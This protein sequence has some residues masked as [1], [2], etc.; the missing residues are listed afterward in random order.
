MLTLN[1][2]FVSGT[3]MIWKGISAFFFFTTVLLSIFAARMSINIR[4]QCSR[5]AADPGPHPGPH[6]NPDADADPDQV[7][8]DNVIPPNFVTPQPS[9]VEIETRVIASLEPVWRLR[10]SRTL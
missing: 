4:K 10:Q 8:V 6:P 3:T 2:I 1:E 5:N 7:C 9:Q